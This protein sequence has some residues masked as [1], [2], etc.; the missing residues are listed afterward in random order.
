MVTSMRRSLGHALSLVLILAMAF[1][2]AGCANLT[3]ISYKDFK[4]AL[5][6]TVGLKKD[7]Y[8]VD[9]NTTKSG[10]D[11]KYSVTA[12]V[13]N[14]IYRFYEFDDGDDAV[15]YFEDYYDDFDE[16]F[17][18]GD[19]EGSYQMSYSSGGGS[20]YVLLNGKSRSSSNIFN[21]YTNKVYGGIYFKDNTVIIVAAGSSKE[22]DA[23]SIDEFLKSIDYPKP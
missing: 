12:T 21:M 14:C 18:E 7:E 17:K 10:Y 8:A 20:G 2:F 6:E 13:G 5:E 22:S 15:D 19:F 1:V 4:S 9:K 3:L 11:I 23:A 16:M